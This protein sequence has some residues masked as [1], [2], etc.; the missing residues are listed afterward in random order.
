MLWKLFIMFATFGLINAH[1]NQADH[2]NVIIM[3]IRNLVI[4]LNTLQ[5]KLLKLFVFSALERFRH[6]CESKR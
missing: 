6:S 2:P 1:V 5:S 4:K 3:N